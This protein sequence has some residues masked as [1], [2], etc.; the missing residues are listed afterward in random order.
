MGS[1]LISNSRDIFFLAPGPYC[2]R[3]Q[4]RCRAGL[5]GQ[6]Q[7][8]LRIRFDFK[9]SIDIF[10]GTWALMHQRPA[11]VQSRLEGA[12]A[13]GPWDPIPDPIVDKYFLMAPEP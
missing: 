12:G 1:D 7:G 6:M 10:Y 13:G 3:G 4:H 11:S 5:Q 8:L 9:L 2:I